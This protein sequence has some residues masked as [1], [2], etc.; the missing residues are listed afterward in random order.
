MKLKWSVRICSGQGPMKG[1]SEKDNET[2]GS[3]AEGNFLTTRVP[4]TS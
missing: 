2:S 3:M 1:A 4:I